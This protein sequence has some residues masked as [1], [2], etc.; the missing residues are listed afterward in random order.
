MIREFF[1]VLDALYVKYLQV[2]ELYVYLV[3]QFG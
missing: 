3:N 1:G 2:F